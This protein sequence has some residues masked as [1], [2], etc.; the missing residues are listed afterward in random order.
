MK[1]YREVKK[2]RRVRLGSG[3]ISIL[4]V[5]LP[6]VSA[7]L[8]AVAVRCSEMSTYELVSGVG[9]TRSMLEHILMSV[10]LIIGGAL[11]FDIAEREMADDQ[12]SI[13]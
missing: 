2:P 9:A 5:G 7:E 10:V 12:N 8:I 1:K 4:R 3:G 13:R 11:L 6:V